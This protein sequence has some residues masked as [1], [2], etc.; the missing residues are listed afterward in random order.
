MGRRLKSLVIVGILVVVGSVAIG[1]ESLKGMIEQE[2]FGW[3]AGKWKASTDDGQEILLSYQWAVKGHAVV[4][5]FKMGDNSSQGM[6]YFDAKEQQVRQFSVDSRGRATK[7]TWDVENGKPTARTKMANEY[8]ETT[9]VAI[10]YSKIDASTMKVEV[11]G[12]ED[13]KLSDYAWFEVSFKKQK[14]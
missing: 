8:G 1:Q 2:G 5:N 4:T 6:I 3:M 14:K 9:D 10:A 13:G 11:F 7:A 12:L